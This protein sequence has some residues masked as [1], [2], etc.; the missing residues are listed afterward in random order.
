[1]AKRSRKPTG[2]PPRL[3]G[4]ACERGSSM[5][6]LQRL[7]KAY[8]SGKGVN[9]RDTVPNRDN[10]IV[11]AIR[12]CIEG[13]IAQATSGDRMSMALAGLF[14]QVK[15]MPFPDAIREGRRLSGLAFAGTTPRV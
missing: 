12:G 3:C 9:A 2:L 8:Q 11:V 4:G 13:N 15:G 14:V 7:G 10:E 5:G 6:N 1:M